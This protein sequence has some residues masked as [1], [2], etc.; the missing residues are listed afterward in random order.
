MNWRIFAPLIALVVFCL[1]WEALVWVNDWPN[2]KMASPSDLA[3]CLLEVPAGCSS[4]TDG[5]RSGEPWRG[6]LVSVAVSAC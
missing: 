3:A 1:L 2:Y 4:S 5:T 6:L